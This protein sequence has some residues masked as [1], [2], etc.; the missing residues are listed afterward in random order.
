[1]CG[2]ASSLLYAAMNIFIPMQYTSYNSFSQSI[3][4]IDASTRPHWFWLG[5]LYGLLV[6]AFGWGVLLSE[7]RSLRITGCLLFAY[8]A[9][10]LFWPSMHLRDTGIAISDTL[11][12]VFAII[13][14][15]LM[16][17][18]MAFAAST[19][20]N[21]FKWY[22]VATIAALVVFGMLTSTQAS[23]VP[24]DLP[25]PWMGVWERINIGVFLLWIVVLATTLLRKNKLLLLAA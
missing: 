24:V 3:S 16:L 23:K 2:I 19:L 13:T 20:G 9:A 11:H 7:N 17:L 12:I 6:A 8:G 5:I 14:V 4:A 15:M 1:M 21:T 10:G 18:A 22:T 25:T